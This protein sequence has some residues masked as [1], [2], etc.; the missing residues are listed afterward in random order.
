[1]TKFISNLMRYIAGFVMGALAISIPFS[2]KGIETYDRYS[3]EIPILLEQTYK[4]G[5]YDALNHGKILSKKNKLEC[6]LRA[7]DEVRIIKAIY[8]HTESFIKEM[9]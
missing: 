2:R 5:C 9:K 1:M 4:N 3:Q 7:E 6:D 8:L